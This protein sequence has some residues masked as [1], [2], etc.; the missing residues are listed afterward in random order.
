M[1]TQDQ[2]LIKPSQLLNIH[3]QASMVMLRIHL[4]RKT[5]SEYTDHEMRMYALYSTWPNF[6][7]SYLLNLKENGDQ[8]IKSEWA[9]LKSILTST[10]Q[11]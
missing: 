3:Y 2:N 10:P 8:P 9:F 5:I 4:E 11:T 6:Y 7:C 1:T